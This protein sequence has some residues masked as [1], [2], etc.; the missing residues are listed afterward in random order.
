LFNNFSIKQIP[1][2]MAISQPQSAAPDEKPANK[3]GAR[4]C[5][6]TNRVIEQVYCYAKGTCPA[7]QDVYL[8]TRRKD[9]AAQDGLRRSV[10]PKTL[11]KKVSLI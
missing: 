3:V 1:L 10:L 4:T 7:L 9:M 6:I 2:K 8:T 11:D 5:E